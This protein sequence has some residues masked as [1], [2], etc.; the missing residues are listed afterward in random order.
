VKGKAY[1]GVCV[2]CALVGGLFA[3]PLG[4][5]EFGG[6]TVTGP[7]LS[8]HG[9]SLFLFLLSA[10]S[11]FFLPRIAAAIGLCAVAA[12]LPLYLFFLAPGLFRAVFGG[13]WSVPPIG[14]FAWNARAAAAIAASLFAAVTSVRSL[15]ARR[16]L[17]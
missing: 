15:R 13:E 5:S 14:R 16:A 7:L 17:R 4:A 2:V 9:F 3:F 12:S 1:A 10:V 6:G 11:M 8:L